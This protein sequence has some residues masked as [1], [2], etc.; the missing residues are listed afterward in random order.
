MSDKLQVKPQALHHSG[1]LATAPQGGAFLSGLQTT[2]CRMFAL[3]LLSADNE[4]Q[5]GKH[6][7]G[8]RRKCRIDADL[9]PG[10]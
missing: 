8:I 6:K 2:P 3:L 10:I 1:W 5:G 7:S 4:L 9:S